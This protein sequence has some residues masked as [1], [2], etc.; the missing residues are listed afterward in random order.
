MYTTMYY[1]DDERI[2]TEP[3]KLNS[4]P[5]RKRNSTSIAFATYLRTGCGDN[6]PAWVS[7]LHPTQKTSIAI[8]GNNPS[9]IDVGDSAPCLPAE[10]LEVD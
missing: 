6:A 8:T 5:S 2:P 4:L 7:H 10:F 9:A 1:M 3:R